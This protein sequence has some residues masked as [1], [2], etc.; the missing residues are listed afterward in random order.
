MKKKNAVLFKLFCYKV[1]AYWKLKLLNFLMDSV[2]M[3]LVDEYPAEL[4][5]PIDFL[6]LNVLSEKVTNVAHKKQLKI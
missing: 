6:L 3:L 1:F 2:L 4:V 5:F